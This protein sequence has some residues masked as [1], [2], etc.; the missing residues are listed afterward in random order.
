VELATMEIAAQ[1]SGWAP[2][3]PRSKTYVRGGRSGVVG[4]RWDSLLSGARHNGRGVLDASLRMAT[5]GSSTGMLRR[6]LSRG[7]QV[8][9]GRLDPVNLTG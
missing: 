3:N 2:E 5:M 1:Q 7:R 6:R 8:R 9:A 4:D